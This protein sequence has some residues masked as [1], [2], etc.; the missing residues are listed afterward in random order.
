MA[1][2]SPI[3]VPSDLKAVAGIELGHA[4][5]GVRKA[6]RKDVLV[7][8]LAE[9]ATVAGVFTKNRFCAAPVQ[10]CQANLA[11]LSAAK[12]IRALVI[13]T[14]N[15]N[16]GTGEEGLQRARSVCAALAQ[17]IGLEPQQILPFS[18]GVILE[19]LPADRII[20][21]LPQAIGN[22][23][24]D[25]WFNAAESIMTTDT[26]PK[27]ASRTLSIGGKQVVMTGIS[28]GAGMIK[29][30]MATMLGFLA[31]DAKLPQALLNQLVKDAAD[32]SFNCI[33][34]DGDT[35]TN[36]S[37]ILMATGAGELEIT[38][39]D[40]DDYKQLAA[41]VTD[42]SQHLAHQI[43][44][45]GEGATKFI[46]V[47]VEDGK[48]VEECRQIAY[49]I[50]HSPLVK[51]AFFASD[52]NL[53]RILAAIGYAGIDDLDV[54]RI[55]LWL[56]DVWVAKDGGR[57]PDYREEDGQRVMKKA[58][59]VVRVKLARGT[60]KASIWTCDLSHDYVSINADYRS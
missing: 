27:A 41:A 60:A 48:S 33:T 32:H 10:I 22:L 31:F 26:Q 56:D 17:Q 36:D 50:G 49:S 12:P 57:N 14:G 2:N 20:A 55:N 59:I 40:S 44:R 54:S 43:V 23:K 29:P 8:K 3:P 51:T 30:N 11:Q 25:N 28:K 46:E 1:V 21:G 35:S 4:E 39:A 53:G 47:A 16:A 18:T 15:A 5:A 42:L 19:P 34:I 45:D 58:E 9:T 13:N 52:P 37:F 6:N 24:A 38:S 7:M